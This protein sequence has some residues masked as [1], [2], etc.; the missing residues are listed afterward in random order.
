MDT[1]ELLGRIFD[2]R[3]RINELIG[4]GGMGAVYRATQLG[5]NREVALKVLGRGVADSDKQAHRFKQEARASSRLQHPNTIRVF[6]S[7]QTEDGRLFL[8]ME[9]LKGDTLTEVLKKE[10]TFSIDRASHI[11]RQICNSLAEAHQNGIVHRDLKPDNI[12]ITDIFGEHDFVKVLDFGIA[13]SS[14][15]EEMASLTQ[16]GFICGTPRYLSPE[17]ALGRPVDG[18]SDLYSLG[19]I[20]YELLTGAPPFMAATP[21]ALVMKHIHEAAPDLALGGSEC[22]EWMSELIGCLLNKEPNKRPPSAAVVSE[23][24]DAIMSNQKP[25]F[26]SSGYQGSGSAHPPAPTTGGVRTLD[27]R[28]SPASSP[29]LAVQQ[30]AVLS[31]HETVLLDTEGLL[32]AFEATSDAPMARETFDHDLSSVSSEKPLQPTVIA[33]LG[34]STDKDGVQ[35]TPHPFGAGRTHA[36]D[37]QRDVGEETGSQ[38]KARLPSTRTSAQKRRSASS[39]GYRSVRKRRLPSTVT[40]GQASLTES[41]EHLMTQAFRQPDTRAMDNELAQ[42]AF[43]AGRWQS[44]LLVGGIGLMLCTIGLMIWRG[45]SES[46]PSPSEAPVER[47]VPV[48]KDVPKAS[49]GAKAQ[50]A[51]DK[52]AAEKAAAEKAAMDK[53]ALDKVAL[54]KAAAEKA[55]LDKAAAGKAAA[56]KAALDKAAAEKAVVPPA[57]KTS[58][59]KRASTKVKKKTPIRAKKKSAKKG[60]S[61]K[62]RPKKKV[63]FDLF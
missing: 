37:T 14:D 22:E 41:G 48:S 11:A 17:Q 9:Y 26:L 15:S 10:K 44:Y 16:T 55:A 57:K 34:V 58:R 45:G 13:K 42:K 6:D 61:K 19:V 8:A 56:E 2:R 49:A 23:A 7:G 51:S 12:F 47:S 21:I 3:Y 46:K 59:P 35:E 33:D 40:P 1:N 30:S 62:K 39:V 28:A 20:L 38:S 32:P 18:R 4:S 54:D 31:T 29:A 27:F 24:L 5:M 50:A 36:E 52:T 53:V 60:K 43:G 63:T 25:E